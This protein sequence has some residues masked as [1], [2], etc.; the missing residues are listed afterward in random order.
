M[1][2]STDWYIVTKQK[3]RKMMNKGKQ[4]SNKGD[5]KQ[6]VRKKYA[7]EKLREIFNHASV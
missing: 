7:T 1:G 3:P 5:V 4:G 6:I 2:G